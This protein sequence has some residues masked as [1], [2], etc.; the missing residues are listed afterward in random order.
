MRKNLK[1]ILK[2]KLPGEKNY[3]I[4]SGD[5]GFILNAPIYYLA[6]LI[7]R[8][9]AKDHY[10]SVMTGILFFFYPLYV[11]LLTLAAFFISGSVHSFWLLILFPFS[12]Y[13]LLHFKNVTICKNYILAYMSSD[14]LHKKTPHCYGVYII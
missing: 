14:Y 9:R 3:S 13:C 6:H 4:C 7:I 10:D 11:V 12:A 1:P 5:W 8:N 2:R